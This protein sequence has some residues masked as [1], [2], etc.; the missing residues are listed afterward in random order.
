MQ[1]I[2][3]S[4]HPLFDYVQVEGP[5]AKDFLQGQLTC[6]LDVLSPEHSL[7]GALCNL[8][9]RVIADFRLLQL[10]PE[11]VLLQTQPGCGAKIISTLERYAVFSK[12]ELAMCPGPTAVYGLISP[13]TEAAAAALQECF[14]SLPA[15]ENEVLVHGDFSV[16]REAGNTSRY[17]IFCHSDSAQ[18][19]LTR[20]DVLEETASANAWL[21][22]ELRA[23]ILH[24][25]AA[26]SENYTP[27]LLNYDISGVVDF[28]KGCY[29]GQEVV[30]RMYYRGKAK[31]R[32]YLL[33]TPA[34]LSL[35]S[36]IS[37]GDAAVEI[38][39]VVA[40][41][42]DASESLALAIVGTELVAE[43]PQLV[44]DDGEKVELLPLPY[45]ES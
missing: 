28:K 4:L 7:M 6:N 24:V 3:L 33:S 42:A 8:K 38:L 31:K 40:N 26:M 41:D 44:A 37:A 29:T 32:L 43:N 14:T 45:A 11:R 18:T 39:A 34:Q 22:E 30:A 21:R 19:A 16:L 17:Q 25:T 10:D 27:Q 13:S 9:G 23:G 36:S 15:A 2:P 5:Q 35:D 1:V 12:A 20:L